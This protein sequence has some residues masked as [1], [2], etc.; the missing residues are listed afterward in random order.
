MVK[1]LT[2][3]KQLPINKAMT[4]NANLQFLKK[5]WIVNGI[6][7]LLFIFLLQSCGEDQ[8]LRTVRLNLTDSI[9]EWVVTDTS[10]FRFEMT[11]NKG[12]S[13][14]FVIR[15]NEHDYSLGSS[16]FMG[17]KTSVT[18]TEYYYQHFQSNYF[19]TFSFY[20]YPADSEEMFGES[21]QFYINTLG[22]HFDFKHKVV[23]NIYLDNHYKDIFITSAGI[24]SD[25]LLNSVF[26][27]LDSLTVNGIVYFNLFHFQLNDL[28]EYW[29]DYTIT[30]IY[31]A[32]KT[33]LV[34]YRMNNGLVF[35][36]FK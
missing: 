22:F 21:I 8:A 26:T 9:T 1:H 33:G 27:T 24:E 15:T 4:N 10:L 5:R 6:L 30:D 34:R 20:I 31:F 3:I 14:E 16:Y 35:D 19:D 7:G 28:S 12:I 29:D 13:R 32:Q 18:H 2:I 11:D 23:T 25:T 17:I 36:R